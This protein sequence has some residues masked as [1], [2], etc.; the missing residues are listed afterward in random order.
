MSDYG[1]TFISILSRQ[2]DKMHHCLKMHSKTNIVR[3][4]VFCI[5]NLKRKEMSHKTTNIDMNLNTNKI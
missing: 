2:G 1:N 3:E 5:L 4:I